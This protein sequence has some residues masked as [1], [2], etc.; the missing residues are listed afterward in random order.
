MRWRRDPE[1]DRVATVEF[2]G[3]DKRGVTYGFPK[4]RDARGGLMSFGSRLLLLGQTVEERACEVP[5]GVAVS[6]DGDERG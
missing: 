1:G 6:V 4:R 5:K 3:R 2:G